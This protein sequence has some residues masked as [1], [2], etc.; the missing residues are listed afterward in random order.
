ME[1]LDIYVEDLFTEAGF[2]P[3]EFEELKEEWRPILMSRIIAKIALKLEP[4]E[5]AQAEIYL[6]EGDTEKFW[7]LCS[8]NIPDY[9]EYFVSILQEFEDDFLENFEE[10]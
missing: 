10:K 2:H 4:F 6:K 8:D 5:R 3:D 9:E 1:N 7:K